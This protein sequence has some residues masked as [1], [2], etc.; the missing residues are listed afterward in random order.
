[1]GRKYHSAR[2]PDEDELKKLFHREEVMNNVQSEV[3][4][5]LTDLMSGNVPHSISEEG[6]IQVRVAD[7]LESVSDY[8]SAVVKS[9]L[10][11]KEKNLKLTEAQLSDLLKLHKG[12]S[13]YSIMICNAIKLGQPDVISKARSEGDTITRQAKVIRQNYLESLAEN[14]VDPHL[15]IAYTATLNSY[16]KIK[17]HL[18]NIAEALAGEK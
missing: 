16:R 12:V 14:R 9:S 2:E 11:M 1:M 4:H 6:R 5:F 15:T 18:L 3:I 8:I 10:T 7:E 13:D 17:D